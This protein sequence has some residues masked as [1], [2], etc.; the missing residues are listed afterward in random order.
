MEINLKNY[1]EVLEVLFD[2]L[3]FVFWK[4]RRGT[5]LGGNLNQAKA[6]GF[7]SQSE[8]IGKTIFDLF[9]DQE[10][11]KL[12]NDTDNKIMNTGNPQIIEE[13]IGEKT[14][15]SQKHPIKDSNGNVIGLLGFAMDVT[16]LKKHEILAKRQ[17]QEF[18]ES[19][20]QMVHDIQ[21]PLSG[22]I[23]T[24]ESTREIPEE[25]RIT[26]RTATINITDITNQLLNQFK[27]EGNELTENNKRQSVLVSTILSE[28]LGSIR[29][30][31]KDLP[32][33]FEYNLT[34][35]NA[36]LFI[37]AAP[38]DFRRSIT[39][40]LKNA[41][42]ALSEKIGGKVEIK[43]KANAEWVTISILDDGKGMSEK[44]QDKLLEKVKV[45]EGKENGHGVGFGQVH[46][47]LDS[48]YGKLSISSSV[49]K[50]SHGTTIVL[51]FPRIL[52]PDWTIKEIGL[53]KD[54]I[55]IILDDDKSIHGAW[56]SRIN[57]ILEKVPSIAIHHFREGSDALAFINKLSKEQ[58]KAVCFLS[59]YELVGQELNG[60]QVIQKS[61]IKHSI[62]VTSHHADTKIMKTATENN[63]KILPKE[64]VFAV[65]FKII[66]PKAGNEL[67]KVHM[68]FVD[69]EKMVTRTLIAEYYNH[70]I[71]DQYSNPFEFLEEVDKYPK[72]TKFILDN[73]Y[74]ADDG[75]TYK[76][77]GISLAE[78]LHKK[79]YTKLFLLSGEDFSTPDYLKLILKSDRE[80]IRHLDRL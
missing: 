18:N 21:S 57:Y 59:D 76:I 51:D 29:R 42:E 47:M 58:K 8:F 69:D 11:A 67:V 53:T 3:P 36:F 71:V 15:L 10:A 45:T 78:T 1:F 50:E 30:K 17:Q 68:V 72:D 2:A 49:R 24:V 55:V 77:D 74:Y 44:L 64:L 38:S 34:A 32:V 43:L 6:F 5:Y 12:I 14:Y 39:N 26:L 54:D 65:S 13:T 40:L 16:E 41:V 79:G 80:S 35:L 61:K 75:S 66:N 33:T 73:Y 31:Y 22:L 48:N 19:V 4:D 52:E 28:A 63:I 27:P 60:L 23:T 25:K 62:L 56:D 20:G 46:R 9:G 37:K 70:L 7:N